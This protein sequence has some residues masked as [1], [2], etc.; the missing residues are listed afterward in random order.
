[1]DVVNSMK[2]LGVNNNF[3]NCFTS[4]HVHEVK[5]QCLPYLE[6]QVK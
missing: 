3:N 4:L 6:N 2:Y 5:K 1:M